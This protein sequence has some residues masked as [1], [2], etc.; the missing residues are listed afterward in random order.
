MF[1]TKKKEVLCCH[2]SNLEGN[3]SYEGKIQIQNTTNYI[4][5]VNHLTI[6][7]QKHTF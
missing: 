2:Y 3:I 1:V 6:P 5:R 7:E 4:R